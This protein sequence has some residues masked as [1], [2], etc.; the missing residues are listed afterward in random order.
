MIFEGLDGIMTSEVIGLEKLSSPITL[1]DISQLNEALGKKSAD[2]SLDGMNKNTQGFAEFSDSNISK[3]LDAIGDEPSIL[4]IALH[5]TYEPIPGTGLS[6]VTDIFGNTRI[7]DPNMVDVFSGLPITV[8]ENVS[9]S[10]NIGIKDTSSE[11]STNYT[12]PDQWKLDRIKQVEAI[13]D[14]AVQHYK[15]AKS[16]GNVEEMLKWE[17]EANK[18]QGLL[19]NMLGISAYTLNPKAPGIS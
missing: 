3:H 14:T 6:K 7:C 2:Q 18:Q 5:P 9:E 11:S 17:A 4:S 12:P 8:P 19:I 16:R 10:S 1:L 15:D 13:R